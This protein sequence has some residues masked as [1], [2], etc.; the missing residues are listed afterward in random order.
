MQHTLG[1]YMYVKEYLPTSSTKGSFYT[2]IPY[3][4]RDGWIFVKVAING[5]SKKY[6]FLFDTGAHSFISDSIVKELNIYPLYSTKSV[7]IT[8]KVVYP[9]LHKVNISLGNFQ[10]S[11]V[12]ALSNDFKNF[13][14]GCFKMDGILG[15]NILN[16]AV[17]HFD[18]KRKVLVITNSIKNISKENRIHSTK[19]MK[20]WQGNS[21]VNLKVNKQR[22]K[23]LFDTG[24]ANF[25]FAKQNLFGE[26]RPVKEKITYTGG[27][28]SSKPIKFS[29]YKATSIAMG[30]K[31]LVNDI[32]NFVLSSKD[33][34]QN[35]LGNAIFT[36]NQVTIDRKHGKLYLAPNGVYEMINTKSRIQNIGFYWSENRIFISS[37]AVGS[38]LEELGI[39]V[40]DTIL[41]INNRSASSFANYCDFKIFNEGVDS[42]DIDIILK[43]HTKEL[44]YRITKQMLY[45]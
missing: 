36:F 4:F 21:F 19:L 41:S 3:E 9:N 33:D 43:K 2:E 31:P 18:T 5:S 39:Q 23:F 32:K 26:Q 38:K 24:S 30:N 35:N 14:K 11:N 40:N 27:L 7:D 13:T 22:S 15:K 34:L 37:L 1:R 44:H 10:S 8:G 28:Y 42:T 45:D 16:G 12:G 25:L 6:D 20:N 29:I 17:F